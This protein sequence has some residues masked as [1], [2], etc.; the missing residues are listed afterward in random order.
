MSL[1]DYVARELDELVSV[2]DKDDY[3]DYLDETPEERV[4]TAAYWA[5]VDRKW[6]PVATGAAN[7]SEFIV[8]S[9]RERR[10]PLE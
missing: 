2:A 1:S 5:E 7:L 10:G 4:E 6:D 3:W 8:N 9:I